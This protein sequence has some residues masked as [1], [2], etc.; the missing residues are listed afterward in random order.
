[1][2]DPAPAAPADPASVAIAVVIPAHGQPGLLPEAIGAVL[3]QEGAPPVAAVVVEDGCPSPATAAL[4][5]AFA[6]AHPGRVFLLRQR[7]RGLSAARNTG[8]DFAL[9]AFPACRALYFLDAD[10]RIL[11][12]F[13]ARGWA[14]LQAAPPETGWFYP[15]IHEL[16]GQ[17]DGSCA[18]DFSLLHLLVL[19]YCEAGSL[20]RRE[21][22]EAGLRF[23][24]TAMR[25]GFEDWDFWLQAGRA[26]FRGQHLADWGFRYR[27]RPESMLAAAERQRDHLL[28][29]LRDRHAAALRPRALAALEAREAPRHALFEVDRAG[30]LLFLD[31]DRAEAVAAP[32]LRRRLL[33]AGTAPGAVHAPAMV[34]FGDGATLGLL[35]AHRLLPMVLWWAERLLRGHDLVALRLRPAAGAEL[36]F[37]LEDG[38]A[39]VA[40]AGL[41]CLTGDGLLRLAADPLSPGL[42]SLDGEAPLPRIA[43]LALAL[44]GRLPPAGSGALRLLQAEVAALGRL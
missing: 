23:D 9:R 6:A 17:A 21:V 27:K 12:G 7:N 36:A 44:P 43:R 13:L 20:V 34:L 30:A 38:A 14:A 40:E 4:A 2:P 24:G 26:G 15:D 28:R 16:G 31:P 18:G 19:N 32:A 3:A 41:L 11:P 25:A 1:M 8:I 42:V 5:A 10:N 29:L 33:A 37:E 39:P 22:F 35:R